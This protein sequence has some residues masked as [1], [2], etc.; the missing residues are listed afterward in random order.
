M[1]MRVE[2]PGW[3]AEVLEGRPEAFETPQERM[4]LVIELARLNVARS[5]GGPFGA[6]VFELETGKLVSV[7]VNLVES[8]NCS[9]LHAEMVALALAQQK[10][11]SWDLGAGGLPAHQLVTS[12]EP[13]AMCLGAIPWSGI[14]SVVCGAQAEDAI[15]IGFDEGEK[16]KDW[17]GSLQR[18]R[19]EVVRGVL[20]E[21]ARSVLIEY[22]RTGGL[23]YNARQAG[24]Q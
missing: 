7:G 22:R 13:C 17:V 6:A 4:G 15:A 1:Q 3:V 20:R 19:I 23:I 21:Q 14:R 10:L 18:R 12:T 5:S 16:P 8:C 24:Q 9:V 11:G 2:L